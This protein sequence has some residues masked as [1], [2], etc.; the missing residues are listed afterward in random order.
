[1]YSPIKTKN[2]N[3]K[4]NPLAGPGLEADINPSSRS[5]SLLAGWGAQGVGRLRDLEI[6]ASE[7]KFQDSYQG[8]ASAMPHE[9]VQLV[10]RAGATQSPTALGS[11]VAWQSHAMGAE[12]W[13]EIF[14][15]RLKAYPDTN[16]PEDAGRWSHGESSR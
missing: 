4:S 7:R 13:S 5:L 16:L 11:W 2:A 1:L 12:P 9:P 3:T 6:G 10:I 14:T 15:V 8:M